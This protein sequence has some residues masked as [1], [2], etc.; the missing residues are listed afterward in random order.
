MGK[1]KERLE[2]LEGATV[3]SRPD[4]GPLAPWRLSIAI[5]VSAALAGMPVYDAAMSGVAADAALLRAFGVAFFVWIAVGFVNKVLRQAQAA[6]D[7]DSS[8][9]RSASPRPWVDERIG[10]NESSTA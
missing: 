2:G 5:A 4:P 7:A 8:G 9:S 1:N 10:D 3:E 6:V